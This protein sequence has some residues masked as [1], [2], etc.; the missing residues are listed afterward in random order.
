MLGLQPS[1]R[2][3]GAL[4]FRC[5][6]WEQRFVLTEGDRDDVTAIGWEVDDAAA[7][8]SVVARLVAGGVAITPGTAAASR[9]S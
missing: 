9:A 1:R 5:D 3:D 6:D 8:E 7:L 2:A 4:V